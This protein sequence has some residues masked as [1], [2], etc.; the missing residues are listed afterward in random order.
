MDNTTPEIIGQQEFYRRFSLTDFVT[1]DNNTDGYLTHGGA[2]FEFKRQIEKVDETLFQAI[3]YLS[4]LRVKGMPVHKHIVLVSLADERAYCYDS[5]KFLPYIERVYIGGA[6]KNNAD[7][8][9]D[10][11]PVVIEYGSDPAAVSALLDLLDVHRPQFTKVHIDLNCVVGWANRFYRETKKSK[12]EMFAELRHPTLFADYLYPWTGQEQDFRF[13][14][15]CLN[16]LKNRRELGAFYTP[17]PFAEKATELVRQAI[18]RVPVQT[19]C[20]DPNCPHRVAGEKEHKHYVIVDRCAGTGVLQAFL[21]DEEL[22]HTVVAT[23]ELKE[24]VVLNTAIGDKVKTIVPADPV[25]RDGLLTDGDALAQPVFPALREYVDD[26]SCS[27]I[28]FENPPYTEAGGRS[29]Y[30]QSSKDNTWKNSPVCKAMKESVNGV[31]SNE[32]SNV[33]LWSAFAYYVKKQYDAYVVFSPVKYWKTQNLVNREF[34]GGFY[35]NRE[36]FGTAGKSTVSVFCW[37]SR[38][39]TLQQLPPLPAYD[40]EDGKAEQTGSITLKRVHKPLSSLYDRRKDENDTDG[41]VCTTDGYEILRQDYRTDFSVKP[42]DND[43]IIAYLATHGFSPNSQG[44]VLTRVGMAN[45]HGFFLRADNFLE[46][47]PLFAA[48]CFPENAWYRKDVYAKTSD[49]GRA[50]ERDD[51]FLKSCLLFCC[52]SSVNKCLSFD[53]S[54]GKRYRNEL[55]LDG[56]TAASRALQNFAL[57]HEET[58]LVSLWNVLLDCAK[59]CEEYNAGYTYG[60]YQIDREINLKIPVTDKHTGRPVLNPKTNKPLYTAKYP[61]LNGKFSPLKRALADYYAR[62][63]E[64]KLFDYGLLK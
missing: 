5:G 3:K 44:R 24:W 42:L 25:H 18:A 23:Y 28:L 9:T 53:G 48:A 51:D 55:C 8:S 59:E 14:M 31:A 22:Q 35:C 21:S 36:H 12:I 43:N 62:N 27:L 39:A 26:P 47:L 40:I 54:N 32:K 57:N 52:L 63:I 30:D 33:F 56:D 11:T 60:V 19:A 38:E 49:G 10:E 50:Y 17:A 20:T 1:V 16:D 15:D 13:I 64:P 41:L 7:F 4:R 34:A 2:L 29:F 6:S 61:L 37:G 45:G 46:K 58:L